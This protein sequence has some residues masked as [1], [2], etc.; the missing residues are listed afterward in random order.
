MN[1]DWSASPRWAL[2]SSILI[3]AS[4]VFAVAKINPGDAIAIS[5]GP[6]LTLATNAKPDTR[7]LVVPTPGRQSDEM[8]LD[9]AADDRELGTW[10]LMFFGLGAVV[11][12]LRYRRSD[13]VFYQFV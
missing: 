9:A 8:Q 7:E 2:L 10:L 12:S 1:L 11:F 6:D 3:I 13:R 5:E 4:L